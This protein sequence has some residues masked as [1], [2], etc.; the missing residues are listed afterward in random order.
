MLAVLAGL[1]NIVA[2]NEHPLIR[3]LRQNLD[4]RSLH[5]QQ[6]DAAILLPVLQGREPSLVL[7]RRALHMTSHAGEVAFPGGRCEP[8]DQHLAMTALRESEE[9]VALPCDSVEVIGALRPA[10]SKAGLL[11]QPVVGLV[12]GTPV[13]TGNPDEIDSVFQVPL[14]HFLE[15][16]PTRDHRINYRGLDLVVPCYRYQEYVI[17]GLTARVVVDFLA[18]GLGHRV[19]F[20]WPPA[21]PA[22]LSPQGPIV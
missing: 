16:A 20:P 18:D 6:A 3:Q 19:D 15:T 12:H 8:D 7:T 4:P 11:V 21:L 5:Q 1:C 2:M 22:F 9:E 13:L 10:R 17:W 14:R